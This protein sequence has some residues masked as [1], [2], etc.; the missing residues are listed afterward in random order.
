MNPLGLI[1]GVLGSG[2]S[3]SSTPSSSLNQGPVTFGNVSISSGESGGIPVALVV[4]AVLVVG[5][6]VFL[7]TRKK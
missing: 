2:G 6:L 4:G 3:G 5:V 7:F 1:A